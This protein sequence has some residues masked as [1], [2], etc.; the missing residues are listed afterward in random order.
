MP[1]DIMPLRDIHNFLRTLI[2]SGN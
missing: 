1:G 2:W